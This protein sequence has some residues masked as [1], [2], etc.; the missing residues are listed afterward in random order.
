MYD[1]SALSRTEALE[2]LADP[3]VR[4]VRVVRGP[5]GRVKTGLAAAVAGVMLAACAPRG[6]EIPKS[7]DAL[8]DGIGPGV[9]L[10]EVV[11]SDGLPFAGASVQVDALSPV[12]TD[13]DGRAV[14]RGLVA[15]VEQV[16]VSA[17]GMEE[18]AVSDVPVSLG[19][20]VRL[21][22]YERGASFVGG[23]DLRPVRGRYRDTARRGAVE[24]SEAEVDPPAAASVQPEQDGEPPDAGVE[25]DDR[26]RD[27]EEEP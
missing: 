23:L 19:N 11:D 20:L 24:A 3:A 25:S 26:V 8:V 1:L 9:L 5:D 27:V 10:I 17:K 7:V 13:G 6:A 12:L 2:R 15:T 22:L 18:T 4:C 14:V 21:G 16:V